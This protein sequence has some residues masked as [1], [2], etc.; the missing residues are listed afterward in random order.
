MQALGLGDGSGSSQRMRK[1]SDYPNWDDAP[2]LNVDFYAYNAVF[3][4]IAG[5]ATSITVPITIQADSKFEWMKST[6]FGYKD[7][8]TEP[9]QSTDVLPL[10]ILIQDSGSGRLLMNAPVPVSNMAGTGQLPFI[11]PESRIFQPNAT[12]SFTLNNLSTSQYDNVEFTML[13]RKIFRG[14]DN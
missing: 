14:E 3:G 9:F 13:G 8:E 12:V 4:T 2:Y 11:L 7:G 1:I 5:S 10:T 6:I